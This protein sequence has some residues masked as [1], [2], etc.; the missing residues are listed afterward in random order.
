MSFNEERL[1]Q[2][3]ENFSGQKFQWVKTNRPELLGKTVRCRTIEPK[4]N[5]FFAVFDDGSSID[6]EQL[7]S[8]LFMLTED[9]QPLTK[10]E[11]E[12]IAGPARTGNRP[13]V[14]PV[15][16]Q[17]TDAVTQ[18]NNTA[19]PNSQPH[20]VASMFDMFDSTD[21]EISLGITV[22]L[23]DQNFLAMLHSNA[24]DKN[25]FMDELTDYVFKVINKKVVKDSIAKFFEEKETKPS[26]INFTEIHE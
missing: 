21:R 1:I 7:N 15:N 5:R 18:S 14:Q 9:M 10:A 4:G 17:I 12:A 22:K 25:K 19:Q 11:V 2:L 20:Q 3:M 13:T 23:P 24:K 8:S 16:P 26:G 6:T